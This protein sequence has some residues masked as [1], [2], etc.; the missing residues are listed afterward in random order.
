MLRGG[1]SKRHPPTSGSS[2]CLTTSAPTKELWE[3]VE[4]LFRE[5]LRRE[6]VGFKL[7]LFIQE[8]VLEYRLTADDR[9][10]FNRDRSL[11]V[12]DFQR[13]F[14]LKYTASGSHIPKDQ[15]CSWCTKATAPFQFFISA[16]QQ[17]GDGKRHQ[18]K[19]DQSIAGRGYVHGAYLANLADPQVRLGG[20][21]EDLKEAKRLGLK[22]LVVHTGKISTKTA[23]IDKADVTPEERKAALDRMYTSVTNSWSTQRPSVHS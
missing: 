8:Q 10:F 5:A 9:T 20:H 11:T 22:G 18:C 4:V 23:K 1:P 13:I 2:S 12:A 3:P 7:H 15:I 16:P 21:I 17:Y 19:F 6:K 14:E